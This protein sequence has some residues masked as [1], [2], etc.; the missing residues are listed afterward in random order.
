MTEEFLLEM[1]LDVI[2]ELR[3]KLRFRFFRTG[4][5]AESSLGLTAP[6]IVNIDESI[7]LMAAGNPQEYGLRLAEMFFEDPAAR[8]AFAQ[9]R[10][11]ADHSPLQIRLVIESKANRLHNLRWE[12]LYDLD[13]RIALCA[14]ENIH[15][16]RLLSS[17][18]V[19]S[20]AP[21][22]W[23]RPRALIFIANPEIRT[24]SAIDV[25]AELERAKHG[26]ENFDLVCVAEPGQATLEALIDHLHDGCDLL[27]LVAHGVQSRSPRVF[28]DGLDGSADAVEVDTL[29]ERLRGLATV[30]LMALLVSCESAGNASGGAMLALGPRL[31]I[32]TG[33]PAVIAMHGQISFDTMKLF[34]PV[35]FRELRRDGQMDRA[36]AVGRAKVLDQPDWWMPVLFS[37]LRDNRLLDPDPLAVPFKQQY[38]EPETVYVPAG[39]FWMGWEGENASAAER[40]YH[41]VELPAYRIGR[42]PVSNRQFAEYVRQEGVPMYPEAGWEGQTPPS[43]RLD[44]PVVGVTWYQAME[45]CHWL[46]AKTGRAY[47]LPSEAQ[48]EKA[49]RGTDGKLFPWGMDFTTERSLDQTASPY[50]C[51]MMVGG[52]REWTL[53]LWGSTS[54]VME[55]PYPWE[56]EVH[57][58]NNPDANEMVLRIFRGGPF[59]TPGMVTCTT[60]GGFLPTKTGLRGNRHG[61][62]V[63]MDV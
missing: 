38:F 6:A 36:L 61:F 25:S 23:Q 7:L 43:D 39:P 22:V 19:Q 32:E 30:P 21:R 60:R 44:E 46:K 55:Y 45:Y 57:R 24:L 18:S 9:A 52:V 2:E 10:A 11:I 5:M 53:S 54:A 37:R 8:A 58:R 42:L 13:R 50:G 49:A 34:L 15:F 35:F 59:L 48:W 33:I 41:K 28:F 63:V 1:S 31:L 17:A 16:S 14:D 4:D 27:Y 62:R 47:T 12:T 40:P 26:L 51:L 20:F 56:R 3:C 29:L